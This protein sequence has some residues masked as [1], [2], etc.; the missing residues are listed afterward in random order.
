MKKIWLFLPLLFGFFWLWI[1]FANPISLPTFCYKLKNVE[2]D[3]YRAIIETAEEYEN[4]KNNTYEVYDKILFWEKKWYWKAYAPNENEFIKNL[5][6]NEWIFWWTHQKL[7]LIDK[8]I[9]INNLTKDIV[10]NNAIFVGY[11]RSSETENESY[12]DEIITYKITKE[13]SNY[14]LV[15][16]KTTDMNKVRELKNKL[17]EFPIARFL[18]ILIETF[19]LFIIVKIFR[20]KEQ[21]SN[22]KIIL[23]WIIPTTITLPILWFI[24]P[25]ILWDGLLYIIIW[26]LLITTIEAIIIKYW[27]KVSRKNAII[28]SIL[29]NVFSFFIVSDDYITSDLRIGFFI[30]WFIVTLFEVSILFITKKFRNEEHIQNKRLLLIW[31]A[32]STITLPLLWIMNQTEN[33][34]VLKFIFLVARIVSQILII[35]H[36]L[37]ISWKNAIIFGIICNMVSYIVLLII[38]LN[39]SYFSIYHNGVPILY[40][41]I[42][43]FIIKLISF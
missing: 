42:P 7:L 28:A 9:D 2:I 32:T 21:L 11:I 3:N 27:L 18:T 35:K 34:L 31:I 17:I 38:P 24:L 19:I 37:K 4:N 20:D 36:R 33:D 26:E 40:Y 10:D 29:C 14:E 15:K 41:D 30:P 13:W 1:S 39:W 12:C 5:N 8:T 23:L 43:S 16:D 25:S 22:K 6:A